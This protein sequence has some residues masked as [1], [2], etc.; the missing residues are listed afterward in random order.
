MF[1]HALTPAQRR[2]FLALADDVIAADRRTTLQEIE[3]LDR[4]TPDAGLGPDLPDG[5]PD[6]GLL[7]T[8]Q[9]RMAVVLDLLVLAHADGELHESEVDS[10]ASVAD[11]L[12][13]GAEAFGAALDWSRRY[14]ALAEAAAAL[15]APR[16]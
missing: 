8:A 11:R 16:V 7:D 2:V 5:P 9:A 4:L 14:Q 15:G 1:L 3:R 12:H 13:V 6:L 10:V